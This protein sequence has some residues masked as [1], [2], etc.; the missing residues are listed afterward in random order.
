M[1]L[2]DRIR[3]RLTLES[4]PSEDTTNPSEILYV[5]EPR[6]DS[7]F[8]QI[9]DPVTYDEVSEWKDKISIFNLGVIHKIRK[10][11]RKFTLE[12]KVS[13]V[14]EYIEENDLVSTHRP[15]KPFPSEE[16]ERRFRLERMVSKRGHVP[17]P[18]ND[19]RMRDLW[20]WASKYSETPPSKVPE[21][22]SE[23]I[24]SN[25]PE[26][27]KDSPSSSQ[28]PKHP[29]GPL[30][31]IEESQKPSNRPSRF[32]GVSTLSAL[33]SSK[34]ISEGLDDTALD[35]TFNDKEHENLE[36]KDALNLLSEV[37]T[38]F[39]RQREVVALYSV[40]LVYNDRAND[41]AVTTFGYPVVIWEA[42][43]R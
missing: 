8:K 40:E 29:I 23:S 24:S 17:S 3:S 2:L 19:D 5:D 7:Y 16:R 6:L 27:N 33:I 25:V 28:A 34:D 37:G 13:T 38:E 9:S 4:P 41:F 42:Q 12:E 30:I 39:G 11:G 10:S 1:R 32:S 18:T 14:V 35:I 21:A 31:L 22:Y 36:S 43:R 26:K 20:I 15:V